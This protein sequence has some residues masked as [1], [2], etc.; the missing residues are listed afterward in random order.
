MFFIL[1]NHRN[2]SLIVVD[3][4]IILNWFSGRAPSVTACNL[5]LGSTYTCSHTKTASPW[6]MDAWKM[7]LSFFWVVPTALFS[8][9]VSCCNKNSTIVA[10]FEAV[11][12]HPVRN[13][14]RDVIPCD[15]C[16][17]LLGCSQD[18]IDPKSFWVLHVRYVFFT[19]HIDQVVI[20][21]V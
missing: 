2:S 21:L 15:P 18:H 7:R 20:L 17:C 9:A 16:F 13:L 11:K 10:G 12:V 14:R 8:G 5:K 1:D 6:K 4:K 3:A 19:S